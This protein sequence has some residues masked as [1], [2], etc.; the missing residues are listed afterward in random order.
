MGSISLQPGAGSTKNKFQERNKLRPRILHIINSFIYGGTERQA[1][2]LLKRVDLDRYDYSLAVLRKEGAL[3]DQIADRF[4]DVQEY[5]L[6]SFYNRNAVCQYLRL[7]DMLVSHRI[8][9]IHAHD[10]Y[11]SIL[12]IIAGRLACVRV[13]ASQ[14]HLKLSDRRIHEWGQRFINR[15]SHRVLVNSDAIRAQILSNSK[16]VPEKIVVVKNGFI[17]CEDETGNDA[18]NVEQTTPR[19]EICRE[20]GLSQ[21]VIMVGIVGRLDRIKGHCYFIEAAAQVAREYPDVHFMIIGDGELKD[22]MS[23]QVSLLGMQNRVH[24]LGYRANASRM[25]SAFDLSVL[26]SLHEGLPNV[27]LE[28]MAAEVPV[29]ATAVGGTTELIIDGL[30]GYLVPPADSN[31]LA[32]RISWALSNRDEREKIAKQAL[33]HIH[34]NFTLSRMVSSVEQIYDEMTGDAKTRG[35]DRINTPIVSMLLTQLFEMSGII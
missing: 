12:G 6:T 4:P 14:R 18:P 13:I 28:A 34:S 11:S 29:V 3:Y 7:R 24:M 9:L 15:A 26:A 16:V 22:E 21:D 1:T 27:V 32:Q 19:E 31:A 8:N 5:R 23:A 30:T 20:L 2:E 33:Q 25:A 10:F 35:Y 17:S